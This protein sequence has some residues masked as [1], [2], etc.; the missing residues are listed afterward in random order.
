M[1]GGVTFDTALE[2]LYKAV[3]AYRTFLSGPS[4]DN[5]GW[6][7]AYDVLKSVDCL[8]ELHH[9]TVLREWSKL[10]AHA[11]YAVFQAVYHNMQVSSENPCFQD[12]IRSGIIDE[13]G[14]AKQDL[15]DAVESSALKNSS[16]WHKYI[17]V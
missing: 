14:N 13:N 11:Q 5:L 17:V 8:Y 10:P 3:H 6:E 4:H 1:D 12:M 16:V 15:M 9:L 7:T 2:N